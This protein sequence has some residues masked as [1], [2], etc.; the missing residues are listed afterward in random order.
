[1]SSGHSKK[2]I[3]SCT[4]PLRNTPPP[5]VE[6]AK[7]T[8]SVCGPASS[9]VP[10]G[11][12]ACGP[13]A[14][15]LELRGVGHKPRK[16]NDPAPPLGC[17]R[18]APPLGNTLKVGKQAEPFGDVLCGDAATVHAR[19]WQVA[20]QPTKREVGERRSRPLP[21]PAPRPIARPVVAEGHRAEE[22]IG[23]QACALVGVEPDMAWRALPEEWEWDLEE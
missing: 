15:E 23:K 11:R 17:A 14:F 22:G 10:H 7:S 21:V 13:R 16:A 18:V 12:T 8:C 1:M 6:L 3:S 5:N 9:M 19:G 4:Q 2:R 20:E